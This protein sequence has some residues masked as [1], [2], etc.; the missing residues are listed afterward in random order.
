MVETTWLFVLV[1]EVFDQQYTRVQVFAPILRDL[2]ITDELI[3]YVA[4][5]SNT[6]FAF[7][8]LALAVEGERPLL[9]FGYSLL[10]DT[11]DDDELEVAVDYVAVTADNLAN[12][13]RPR[14]GGAFFNE[15]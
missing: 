4:M 1:D 5:Q 3:R 15:A 14:F 11:L 12:Q 10:G 6:D 13:L 9:S 8:A 7:G 2:P